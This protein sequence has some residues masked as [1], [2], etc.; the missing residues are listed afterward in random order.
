[1]VNVNRFRIILAVLLPLTHPALSG[2]PQSNSP[3]STEAREI[4]LTAG[5]YEFIPKL[6][7]VKKGDHVKLIITALD[8]DH[9]FKLEPFQAD[10]TLKNSEAT[11]IV[12][13]AAQ[14]GTFPFECSHFCS[15]GHRKMGMRA[16]CGIAIWHSS[17]RQ[18][19]ECWLRAW[20]GN[21]P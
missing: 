17:R 6:I 20:N 9:G 16:D 18:L 8:A 13:T 5:K 3:D 14:T 12:F 2:P 7:R 4:K 1:M 21:R 15:I 19:R 10:Q 11:T